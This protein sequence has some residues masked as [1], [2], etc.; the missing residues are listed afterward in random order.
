MMLR[1]C[2]FP[3]DSTIYLMEYVAIEESIAGAPKTLTNTEKNGNTAAKNGGL[4]RDDEKTQM[5]KPPEKH[6]AVKR[7]NEHTNSFVAQFDMLYALIPFITYIHGEQLF[8]DLQQLYAIELRLVYPYCGEDFEPVASPDAAVDQHQKVS[9]DVEYSSS[10]NEGNNGKIQSGR[11]TMYCEG[12]IVRV[13]Y[14]KWRATLHTPIELTK[15]MQRCNG[16][17]SDA[18]LNHQTVVYND[19]DSSAPLMT[20]TSITSPKITSQYTIVPG[21]SNDTESEDL[22]VLCRIRGFAGALSVPLTRAN[23]KDSSQRNHRLSSTAS[24]LESQV[25]RTTSRLGNKFHIK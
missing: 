24:S 12:L 21:E 22:P 14:E 5:K 17:D 6:L 13:N 19:D 8:I 7:S 10:G 9:E 23:E 15:G 3:T 2:N 11:K 20:D 1:H 25:T 4:G 18:C 16:T